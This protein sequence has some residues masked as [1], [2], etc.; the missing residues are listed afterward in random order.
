M[1][2]KLK[3]I[4]H[5]IRL[6]NEK[7]RDSL[8]PRLLG[9]NIS[10]NFMPS[11]ANVS[12][13]DISKYKIVRK[14][15]FACNIMHVG[16]D[17]RLPIALYQEEEPAIVSPAYKTFEVLD[18]NEILPEYLMIYFQRGEFD[19][20]AWYLCDSSIRGGLEWERFCEIKILVPSLKEQK[21][22]T[23][24][25][26]G[27]MS[28]QQ[29]Y[30]KS[31]SDLKLICNTFLEGQIKKGEKRKLGSYIQKS[32]K[33]NSELSIIKLRG[34][35]TSKKLIE[36]KANTTGVSFANY[37]IVDTGQFAYVADTSRRGDKIAL[38]INADE[39]CIV[40][41]IYTVFEV[42]EGS[43]LIPEYLYLWFSRPEFDRYARY[44]SW[45]SAR[46]IFDWE[47]MCDVGLSIPSIEE[48]ES[49][50]AIYHALETRKSINN[51]LKKAIR[52]LCPVLMQGVVKDLKNKGV[53]AT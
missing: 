32:D 44:Y 11:V 16:R 49:I 33:K 37:R 47:D 12:G 8:V 6:I 28:N 40:S 27:L 51:R 53:Q 20:L 26:T 39:P 3:S 15:Y 46:E 41:S 42:K 35:S 29:C 23:S 10:K 22:Y 34:I 36:S 7:N 30:E 19:R 17:E 14:G 43:G 5:L 52:P 4:G 18:Q 38:A 25:Y 9:I 48:Q 13:T 2:L 50:V 24:L 45:G 1:Q 21:K 31:L